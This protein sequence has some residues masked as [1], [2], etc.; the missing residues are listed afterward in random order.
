VIRINGRVG[1]RPVAGIADRLI[2]NNLAE[3]KAERE[4]DPKTEPSPL[5]LLA[6]R[7]VP[8]AV[9]LFQADLASPVSGFPD[10]RS[11]IGPLLRPGEL[12]FRAGR[13]RSCRIGP[14]A[15]V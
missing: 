2:V 12:T 10:R 3:E 13:G 9:L 5:T 14:A 15:Y 4:A 11:V 7:Q 1:G 8:V 6:R